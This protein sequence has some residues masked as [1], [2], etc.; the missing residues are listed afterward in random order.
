MIIIFATYTCKCSSIQFVRFRLLSIHILLSRRRREGERAL[1][2]LGLNLF[3]GF[4]THAVKSCL[5]QERD[6]NNTVAD[7]D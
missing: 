7:S 3:G 5:T 1:Y 6:K 2:F 4:N